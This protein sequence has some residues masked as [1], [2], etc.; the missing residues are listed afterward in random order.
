MVIRKDGKEY[1]V[2][3]L[4]ECWV[5]LRRIGELSVEYKVPKD[6]CADEAALRKYVKTEE[7]F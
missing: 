2:T 5:I 1:S 6:I 3:E 7:I 4:A